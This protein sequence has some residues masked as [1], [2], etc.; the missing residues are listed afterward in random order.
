MTAFRLFLAACWLGIV[1]YSSV[2]IM[3]HG[4][5]LFPDWFRDIAA[6]GWPGQ[7]DVDFMTFLML[8]AL[9]VSWRSRFRPAALALG[10]VAF[11]GGMLFLSTYLLILTSRP[12]AT[13]QAILL[14]DHAK[15]A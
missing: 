15:E 8:S 6:M 13:I 4:L 5:N 7:F 14:G 2:T 9:W 3:N 12:G 10:V 1:A 11:L